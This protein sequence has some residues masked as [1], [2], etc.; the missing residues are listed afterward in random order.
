MQNYACG[1]G[2]QKSRSNYQFHHMH[3]VGM[4]GVCAINLTHTHTHTGPNT[5]LHSR[6]TMPI[7][8]IF[9]SI[10]YSVA[11]YAKNGLALA[12]N[13]TGNL[14]LFMT[15]VI[16]FIF[17]LIILKSKFSAGWANAIHL[18]CSTFTFVRRYSECI[19]G[20]SSAISHH[21]ITHNH[22]S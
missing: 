14:E 16:P 22:K 1:H 4:F 5:S 15:D 21:L 8:K 6:R 11:A 10:R 7:F 3:I 19:Q 18:A 2:S 20:D 17:H 12:H 9:L 13:R